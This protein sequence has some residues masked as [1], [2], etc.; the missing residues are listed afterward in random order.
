MPKKK[1]RKP[2]IRV[3]LKVLLIVVAL[4]AFAFIVAAFLMK[5]L[6]EA[7][8]ILRDAHKGDYLHTGFDLM[9]E[10]FKTVFIGVCIGLGVEAYLKYVETADEEK[11]SL[12]KS[13]IKNIYPT[14][15]AVR[16]ELR[17]IVE[18]KRVKTVYI[19]GISLREFLTGQGNMHAV[20]SKIRHQL[21]DEQRMGLAPERRLRV[22]L[23]LLDPASGE[24]YFRYKIEDPIAV[25]N[26][27]DIYKGLQEIRHTLQVYDGKEQK[28]FQARLY[29]HCPFSFMFLTETGVF[30]EQYFYR[31]NGG[32]E[33]LLPVIE[34]SRE[35]LQYE[36]LKESL[37][38]VWKHAHAEPVQ[39]GTAVPVEEARI[40]NIYRADKRVEQGRHQIER[41]K[42]NGNPT[43][44][45]LNITGSFY[46][47]DYDAAKALRTFAAQKPA[48]R[49]GTIRF[50]LLNPVCQQAIFRAVADGCQTEDI[51]RV[52]SGY[53][54][55]AHE[56]SKLYTR[57]RETLRELLDW[58]KKGHSVELRL[59][60]CSTAS[61]LLIT[62]ES[63]FVGQ[64]IYGRSRSLQVENRLQSEYP[65]VEFA[66][67]STDAGEDGIELE[68][69]DSSFKI[70]WEYYS[71][72][73]DEFM[74]RD[75][76]EEFD[77]N[78]ARL[79]EELGLSN[80]E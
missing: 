67:G 51:G 48:G 34:Y 71:I 55:R 44:D 21:A 70:I 1:A 24:G 35:S 77:R 42:K 46:V 47:N 72:T 39:V 79:R 73:H 65:M 37:E 66:R 5:E 4:A 22:R 7:E 12:E 60:S 30:V 62:S 9:I 52:L 49:G 80:D 27:V 54:W 50:A 6:H 53:D 3:P 16:D 56:H 25:G 74:R 75:E 43:V 10:V 11:E 59:Y 58:I 57:V 78:L 19:M 31:V 61:A 76:K 64:Y 36:M 20:W 18:D 17:Q 8:L 32:V 41:V 40:R 14:R 33:A 69:L 13:G 68:I 45:I 28:F 38:A 29:E 15:E 2:P 26:P 23:L 63:A